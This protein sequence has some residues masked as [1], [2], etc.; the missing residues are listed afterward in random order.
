MDV[1]YRIACS[2]AVEDGKDCKQSES[3]RSRMKNKRREEET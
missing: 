2:Y 1:S 3:K